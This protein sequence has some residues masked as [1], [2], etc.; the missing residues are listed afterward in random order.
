MV[1]HQEEADNYSTKLN[2]SRATV[3]I[4]QTNIYETQ[5][6]MLFSVQ[7]KIIC[8]TF[9]IKQS[10]KILFKNLFTSFKLQKKILLEHLQDTSLSEPELS[11]A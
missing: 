4:R 6:L 9:Y 1:V 2:F 3:F 7:K 8:L 11:K 10:L 5:Y